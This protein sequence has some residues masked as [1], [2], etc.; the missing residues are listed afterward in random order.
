MS[1][2][3]GRSRTGVK[4][5]CDVLTRSQ[6]HRYFDNCEVCGGAGRCS[7]CCGAGFLLRLGYGSAVEVLSCSACESTGLCHVC[8]PVESVYRPAAAV[9]AS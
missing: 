9:G 6:S 5:R 3:R 1:V 7:L 2:P 4:R 8:R